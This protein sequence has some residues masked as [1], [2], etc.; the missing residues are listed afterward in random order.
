M[1]CDSISHF[2]FQKNCCQPPLPPLEPDVYTVINRP[3][4]PEMEHN[5]ALFSFHLKS[6]QVSI[7]I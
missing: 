4:K 6:V 1:T 5:L 2:Y 3:P 7:T